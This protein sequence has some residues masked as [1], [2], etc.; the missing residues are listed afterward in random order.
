M[1]IIQ[2]SINLVSAPLKD[3]VLRLSYSTLQKGV[4]SEVRGGSGVLLMKMRD[5]E[6]RGAEQS[7][8]LSS[9]QDRSEDDAYKEYTGALSLLSEVYAGLSKDEVAEQIESAMELAETE[10]E[11]AAP[12][13]HGLKKLKTR[14]A[15]AVFDYS[16]LKQQEMEEAVN[17]LVNTD[18]YYDEVLPLDADEDIEED[19]PVLNKT[20]IILIGILLALLVGFGI[21]LSLAF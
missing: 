1:A 11:D 13:R 14:I 21:Y 3:G 16:E 2:E 6:L 9:R 7:D 18:G 5:N 12:K 4:A 8:L 19:G 10:V 17:E 20:A 15:D